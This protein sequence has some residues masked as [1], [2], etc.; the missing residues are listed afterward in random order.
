MS[1]A[2]IA[3]RYAKSLLDLS[4]ER[5]SLELVN[6]DMAT[7]RNA[8]QNKELALL[9]KSPIIKADKKINVV[10]AIFKGKIDELTLAYLHLL[11]NKGREPFLADIATE[12]GNQYKLLKKI[13]AVKVTTAAPLTDEVLNSIKIKIQQSGIAMENLE[14][15]TTVDPKLIGGF[16]L[17][18]DNKRYDASVSHKLEQ[19]K[20]EFSKN[21]YVKEF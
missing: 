12:F 4:V 16:V 7:L 10:D 14:V 13:T 21:L 3:T 15:Q 1:V 5:G 18:F 2:R 9:L 6:A 8:L 11:I 20:S 17:E 19:L